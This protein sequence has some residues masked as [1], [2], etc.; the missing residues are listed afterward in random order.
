MTPP[1]LTPEAVLQTYIDGS[2]DLDVARISTCFHPQAVMNGFLMDTTVLGTPALYLDDVGRMLESGVN[3]DSY[4]G[5]FEDLVIQGN[6]ASATVVMTNFA[7]LNFKD[8]MHL[9][10][11]GERWTIVSKLFTTL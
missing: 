4:S 9:I 8:F 11:E 3:N 6:V 10:R 7:G 5:H 1:N 2:K